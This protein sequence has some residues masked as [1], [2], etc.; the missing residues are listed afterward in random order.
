MPSAIF[1]T[2]I[3]G[4]GVRAMRLSKPPVIPTEGTAV[5]NADSS[6]VTNADGAVVINAEE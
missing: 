1:T 4:G 2:D 6:P 5:T 3:N